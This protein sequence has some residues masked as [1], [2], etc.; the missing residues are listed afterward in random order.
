[1]KKV[2][3]ASLLVIVFSAII[4][5]CA[6]TQSANTSAQQTTSQMDQAKKDS[7]D[8]ETKKALS[9][10]TEYYKNGQYAEAIPYF[11][12][13]VTELNPEEDR[14]WKYLADSY[15]RLNL[16]DSAFAVYAEGISK[17]PKIA[18]LHR[19]LAVLYQKKASEATTGAE[20]WVDSAMV[21]YNRAY[22]LD[23]KESFSAAQIGRIF[24][25]RAQL[26]S[27]IY[28]FD[29][30]TKAD[31]NDAEIWTR[32]EELYQV[33]GNWVGLRTVYTNLHRLDTE[34]QEYILNL[35]R[36]LAN[37]GQ[38]DEA[39]ATLQD[40]ITKNP[41]DMKGY[42]FM[43]LIQAANKKYTDAINSFKEAEKRAPDNSKLLFD[44]A[45]TY[46]EMEQFENAERY[47][48]KGR[49]SDQSAPQ[50][51]VIEGN[52]CVGRVRT[53]VPQEGIGV[54]DK[55]KFE[56][57]FQIYQRVKS[58]G[59]IWTLVAK[60]KMDYLKTY[61]PTEQERKEFF[62]VHPEL[63]GKICE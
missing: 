22:E 14:A 1:M 3:L 47:L 54:R 53:Q 57:C 9:L 28:W 12:K 11:K 37:T 17:F 13:I 49:K 33:R 16:P 19:G 44:I 43:G 8:Y 39:M 18:Y 38:Y 48:S 51:I 63:Q 50:G 29:V 42:Q 34:N 6:S 20:Q 45:D 24:V 60:S 31:S 27:A 52:I 26:D 58:D 32:L 5:S 7:L 10:G 41:D 23:N 56:C 30:S 35:A 36:A 2:I 55:L 40:Y 15:F 62:F 46:V 61:L 4:I 21:E 59:G 25:S